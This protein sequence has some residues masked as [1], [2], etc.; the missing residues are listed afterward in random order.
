MAAIVIGKIWI[1]EELLGFLN[2]DL[3]IVRSAELETEI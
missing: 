2:W 3:G 1:L